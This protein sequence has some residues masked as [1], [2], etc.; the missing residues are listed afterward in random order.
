[1]LTATATGKINLFGSYKDGILE[2]SQSSSIKII[3]HLQQVNDQNYI[4][5]KAID[6]R[7]NKGK[8]G[9]VRSQS[10]KPA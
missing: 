1:M 7:I 6:E 9:S 3:E 8:F 5:A 4:D 2:N 10:I